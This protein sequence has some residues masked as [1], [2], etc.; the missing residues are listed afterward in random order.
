MT[1]G[2]LSLAMLATI[3]AGITAF[4]WRARGD[5]EKRLAAEKYVKELNEA[6]GVRETINHTSDGD[7]RKRLL[8][9]W[10]K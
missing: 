2:F 9:R 10:S 8:S 7:R 3:A 5:R 1:A 4:V 6:R